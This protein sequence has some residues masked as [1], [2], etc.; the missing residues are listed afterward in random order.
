MDFELQ[1][2]TING[3]DGAA[4]VSEEQVTAGN[5]DGVAYKIPDATERDG[6]LSVQITSCNGETLPSGHAAE[7]NL[8]NTYTPRE[9]SAV[10]RIKRELN[11]VVFSRVRLW[12]IIIAIFFLIFVVI[13]ISLLL[14][15]AIH[16]DPDDSFDS[17]LF[18]VPQYFNGSFQLPDLVFTEELFNLS[19]NESQ[20]LAG[21]LQEKLVD[22]YRSSPALGRYFSKAEIYAFRNGS[23]IADYQLTFLMP[24]EQL[25]HLRNLTL[26]REMVY[27]VFRQ[28][29]YDQEP[30]ESGKIYIDPVSLNMHLSH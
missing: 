21:D 26:S 24:E 7:I 13:I 28:F 25:D 2:I 6:L 10:S 20:V 18:K 22:L 8:G 19:S 27:N 9:G 15:S 29:L 1:T 14:C 17:S 5:G 30:D 11:E 23:V 16:E 3:T 4:Y 12:M